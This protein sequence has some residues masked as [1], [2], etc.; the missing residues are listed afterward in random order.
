MRM[1]PSCQWPGLSTRLRGLKD[2][3]RQRNSGMDF[4]QT[5]R[6]G[7]LPSCSLSTMTWC[8]PRNFL[9]QFKTS[10]RDAY[11]QAAGFSCHVI[12][13]G[14]LSG[15]IVRVRQR[16]NWPGTGS[17]RRRRDNLVLSTAPYVAFTMRGD[18]TRAAAGSTNGSRNTVSWKTGIFLPG[19]R[20]FDP[21]G[22]AVDC[23]LVHL[24]A[25]A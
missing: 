5:L 24:A 6:E 11:P 4:L 17:H 3:T 14:A 16:K 20:S 12:A 13:D 2:L 10:S 19:L 7:V 15:E 22:Q 9:V 18:L 23:G 25:K 1:S 8:W 21:T